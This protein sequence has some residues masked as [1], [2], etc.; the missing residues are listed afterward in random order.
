MVKNPDS[1][2]LPK[3]VWSPA[4]YTGNHCLC[5]PCPTVPKHFTKIHSQRISVILHTNGE[6]QKHNLHYS[7]VKVINN[8]YNTN[9]YYVSQPTEKQQALQYRVSVWLKL[10]LQERRELDHSQP[11]T[12]YTSTNPR[13]VNVSRHTRPVCSATRRNA[14]DRLYAGTHIGSSW[15]R[16]RKVGPVF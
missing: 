13:R 16:K 10:L 11:W 1:P 5:E 2:A 12:S 3:G 6:T 8:H 4:K 9:I 15:R 7:S 14:I